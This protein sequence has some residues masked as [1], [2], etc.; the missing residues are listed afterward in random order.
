MTTVD[1]TKKPA[2]RTCTLPWCNGDHFQT[3]SYRSH[4]SVVVHDGPSRF[5]R[6]S[7]DEPLDA[8][9]RFVDRGAQIFVWM[10][11][12][13]MLLTVRDAESLRKMLCAGGAVEQAEFMARMLT[14]T[15]GAK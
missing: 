1:L 11:G 8:A 3:R 5:G 6:I 10:H 2:A 15:G 14:L 7:W 12:A 4:G 9:A 13:D